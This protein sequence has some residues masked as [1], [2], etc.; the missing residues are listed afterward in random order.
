[1]CISWFEVFS[2]GV[3]VIIIM[4]MVFELKVFYELML[5]VLGELV[6]GFL[7]YLLSF[8]Y[9]GIYWSNYYYMF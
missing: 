3:L 7:M 2:D 9:V 8:V 6:I 5:R 4:I 1:M